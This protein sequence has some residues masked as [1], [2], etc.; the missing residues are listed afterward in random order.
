MAAQ[1]VI[2]NSPVPA[3]L[4]SYPLPIPAEAEDLLRARDVIRT[5]V[6]AFTQ[7]ADEVTQRQAIQHASRMQSQLALNAGRRA[8]R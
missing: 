5:V 6:E 3:R 4:R 7:G 8:K 1:R 2:T